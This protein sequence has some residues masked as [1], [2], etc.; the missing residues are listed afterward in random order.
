MVG[1]GRRE[2]QVRGKGRRVRTT[3]LAMG[4]T[5]GVLG[6]LFSVMAFFTFILAREA[7]GPALPGL[8]PLAGILVSGVGILA[9]ALARPIPWLGLLLFIGAALALPYCIGVLAF[10]TT[11]LFVVGV[12][13]TTIMGL[14]RAR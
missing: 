10:F 9:G 8:I 3:A 5:G 2:E 7:G 6:I 14:S 4:I 12:V 1:A 13:V 11:P